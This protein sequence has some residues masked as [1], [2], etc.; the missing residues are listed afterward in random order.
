MLNLLEEKIA[1]LEKVVRDLQHELAA[2][3]QRE[4]S[5]N[6]TINSLRA[7]DEGSSSSIH[8]SDFHILTCF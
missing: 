3:S 1:N 8:R 2:A 7:Q 6:A 5:L 4:G